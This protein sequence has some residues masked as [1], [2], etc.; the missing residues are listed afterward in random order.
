MSPLSTPSRVE[1]L[2]GRLRVMREDLTRLDHQLRAASWEDYE[3][4]DLELADA[5]LRQIHDLL[6]RH[7]R[8]WRDRQ[9]KRDQ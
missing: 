8:R 6:M 1:R 5:Q 2:V 7:A 3:L 4:E 9:R